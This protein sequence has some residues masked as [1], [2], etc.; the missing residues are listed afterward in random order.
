MFDYTIQ[1]IPVCAST[2]GAIFNVGGYKQEYCPRD[3]YDWFCTCK[4][5]QFRHTCKHVIEAKKLFCGWN[6][7]WDD[8]TQTE[9][10]VCPRCGGETTIEKHAV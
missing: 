1:Y 7:M 9:D 10:H 5:F 8:E 3:Q 2:R 6:S 4:G